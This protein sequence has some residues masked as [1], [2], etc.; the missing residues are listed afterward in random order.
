MKNIKYTIILFCLF[1]SCN[2]LDIKP[3]LSRVVPSTL[4]DFQG[5]LDNTDGIFNVSYV[6]YGEIACADYHIDYQDYQS[7]FTPLTSQVYVWNI[8][9]LNDPYFVDWNTSYSRILQC[10]I[11]LDGLISNRTLE[12]NEPFKNVKGQALFHR[13]HSFFML[14]EEF[15]QVYDEANLDKPALPLRTSSDININYPLSSVRDTYGLIINDLKVASALLPESQLYKTRPSKPAAYALL[16]R[17]FLAKGDYTN[18]LIYADSC[19]SMKSDLMDF[20][21][22]NENSDYPINQFNKEVLFQGS[23]SYDH[24]LSRNVLRINSSLLDL[25][26]SNDLRRNILFFKRDDGSFGFKGNYNGVEIN[27]IFGGI[28]TDEILLV[29]TECNARKNNISLALEGLN[30]LLKKR[31]KNTSF[32]PLNITNQEVLLRRVLLERRKEL[33]FR[34][35][36][37]TDLRRL[38]KDSRFEVTLTRELNGQTYTLQPNDPSYVFPIPKYVTTI[39][40]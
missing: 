2:K 12:S 22:L 27:S 24:L 9:D 28:A 31:Y 4:D 36:R 25:Y 1:Q 19:L 6:N 11:V 34:G 40:F 18:A 8:K 3:D 13:A 23:I 17:V 16:A 37:W 35:L 33:L 39:T 26:E 5:L 29:Q 10:N 32:V 20:N 14:A 38:N 15:A 7:N 30:K 21:D